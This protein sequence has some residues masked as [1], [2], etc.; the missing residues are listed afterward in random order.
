MVGSVPPSLPP[1]VGSGTPTTGPLRSSGVTRSHGYYGPIRHPFASAPFPGD[2]GYGSGPAPPLSRRGEEGFASCRARPCRRAAATTPPGGSIDGRSVPI[3]LPSRMS[4]A[5][6][7]RVGRF[8]ATSAFTRV[9]ARRLARRPRRL[10]SMGFGSSVSLPS[11]IQ[12]TGLRPSTPTGLLFLL[13]APAFAGRTGHNT[14]FVHACP[15][16]PTITPSSPAD[17]MML[18]RTSSLLPKLRA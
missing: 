1:C 15:P 18:P 3:L 9:A 13:D 14:P 16:P 5:L 8:G 2:A 12:A 7:P 10:S 4:Q 6:G 11:A 17:R